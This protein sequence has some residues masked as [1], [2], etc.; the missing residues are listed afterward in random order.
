MKIA[1]P[2]AFPKGGPKI[3]SGDRAE[4]NDPPRK[5]VIRM[6]AGGLI[7]GDSHYFRKAQVRKAHDVT[8]QEMLNVEKMEDTPSSNLGE[9]ND[10]DQKP[11]T[12]MLSSS[13]PYFPT[14]K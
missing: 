12:M 1:S 4:A 11:L 7:G 8:V 14:T 13:L 9:Q 5:E 2:E 6:I 3:T 10:Q